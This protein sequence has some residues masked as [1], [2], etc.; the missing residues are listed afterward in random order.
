MIVC[1][2]WLG[3][4]QVQ[5]RMDKICIVVARRMQ[6]NPLP[7][8]NLHRK[9]KQQLHAAID[10]RGRANERTSEP[11]CAPIK[12]RETNIYR[13][14]MTYAISLPY[15]CIASC[16][17]KLLLQRDSHR[18]ARREKQL[19]I[20][21]RIIHDLAKKFLFW[22]RWFCFWSVCTYQANRI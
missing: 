19:I 9:K 2:Q 1:V 13:R 12:D 7:I 16:A 14:D 10:H 21:Q 8:P 3:E 18:N 4:I 15:D 20:L 22:P 5:K 17:I 11:K 6:D